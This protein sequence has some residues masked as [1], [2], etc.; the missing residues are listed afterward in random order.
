M[1]GATAELCNPERSAEDHRA[2]IKLLENL[3]A[4]PSKLGFKEDVIEKLRSMQGE[5]QVLRT[6]EE[7]SWANSANLEGLDP[8]E[9]CLRA[10]DVTST[11]V[12]LDRDMS[13]ILKALIR[14]E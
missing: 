10:L 13:Y 7:R 1:G 11:R 12:A 6:R 5:W 8:K 2:V 4:D 3:A 14:A 9:R